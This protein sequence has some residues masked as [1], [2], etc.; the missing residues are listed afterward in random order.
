[1]RSPRALATRV[2]GVFRN[3]DKTLGGA[4]RKGRA[5]LEAIVA[6]TPDRG[7]H[8]SD[9]PTG[10]PAVVRPGGTGRQRPAPV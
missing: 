9:H 3:M 1:M 5:A 10:V 7:R 6:G 4:L 8:V 2:L